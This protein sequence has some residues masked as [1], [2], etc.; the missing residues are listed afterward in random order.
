MS[1]VQITSNVALRN[2]TTPTEPAV[3]LKTG[4]CKKSDYPKWAM[5]RA[6]EIGYARPLTETQEELEAEQKDAETEAAVAA[7]DNAAKAD[8]EEAAL[9]AAAEAKTKKKS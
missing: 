4:I 1:K 8:K 6:L 3:Y 9:K 5:D 7:A 2:P